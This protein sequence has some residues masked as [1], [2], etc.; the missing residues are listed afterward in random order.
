MKSPSATDAKKKLTPPYMPA[1]TFTGYIQGLGVHLPMRIDRSVL[2]TYAGGTQSMLISTLRYFGLIDEHGEPQDTLHHLAKAQGTE[3]QH[4]LHHMLRKGYPFLFD[5]GFDLGRATPAQIRE[6][7]EQA[8]ATGE[9][10]AKSIS[11][12]AAL[13]KDAGITL[14][15]TLK[16]RERRANGKRPAKPKDTKKQTVGIAIAS[17]DGVRKEV[18]DGFGRLPIPGLDGAFIQYPTNLT[19][20]D[21]NLFEAMV[22]V[23]RTYVK[24]RAAKKEKP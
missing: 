2:G 1:R 12:F 4:A 19:E 7:F 15:P 23:L 14:T 22:G 8:G 24:G 21:C 16:T 20:T 5:N 9:T 6:R 10:A 17:G 11:F 13:A 18:P 3:R